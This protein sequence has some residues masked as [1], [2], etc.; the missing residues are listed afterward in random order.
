MSSKHIVIIP[1]DGIG[2][3][4]TAEALR[5][6][7]AA[8]E[9]CRVAFTYENKQAGG[10]AI[11]ACGVPLPEDTIEACRQADGV[12]LGA[13]GG[14][15]WD[16]VAPELRA[17]KA[18]LGLR[19]SLGLYANLRPVKV[20]SALAG[21]SPLKPE[22]VKT[23]DI[24]IVR[25][26]NGGIYY[27]TRREAAVVN[28]IEQACDNEMYSRPEIERIVRL[29]C[30][31]AAGRKGRVVSVDKANVLATSRLWRKVAN[32]VAADFSQVEISHMYVDNCAMQL[33]LNPG[34]FDVIVTGNLFGD[35]LSDE[36][37]VLSGSIGL[38]PSASLG[39]GTGLYEPIHGSAPDIAGKG[40]ANPL[41]TILSAAMMFRYSLGSNQVADMIEDAV[42][43]VLADGYR[44][45]DIYQPGF[46]RVTTEEMGQQVIA[47]L[48]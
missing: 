3:E 23:V 24:L 46:T 10:A 28:G 11:D 12:L 20:F 26:L 31:A 39:D 45:A 36:A 44:T 48:K 40:L 19:K 15:K 47:R 5:V 38:L 17:E 22:I 41:G 16:Q 35:I 34:S 1:G 29:A 6:S 32:E 13:V 8:A 33:V 14:P 42:E 43:Q 30:Q 21:Q 7:Q 27:G 2:T 9:K 4:I 18:I 37:A 25:E